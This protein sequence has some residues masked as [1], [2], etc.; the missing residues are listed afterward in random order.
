MAKTKTK[1]KLTM[2]ALLAE[3][4]LAMKA[5]AVGI[6]TCARGWQ[7][8]YARRLR[9]EK[10]ARRSNLVISVLKAVAHAARAA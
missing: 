3:R 7:D 6:D 10:T 1:P 5:R 8:R 2:A 9:A 4:D